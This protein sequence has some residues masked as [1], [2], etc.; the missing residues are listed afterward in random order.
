MSISDVLP[1]CIVFLALVASGVADT[2]IAGQCGGFVKVSNKYAS[3]YIF[4][5]F[6]F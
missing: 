3:L 2:G 1:V 6:H 5:C 4:A